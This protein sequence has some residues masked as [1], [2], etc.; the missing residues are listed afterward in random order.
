MPT[1]DL[2]EHCYRFAGGRVALAFSLRLLEDVVAKLGTELKGSFPDNPHVMM[3]N[4]KLPLYDLA[5]SAFI[6]TLSLD[7]SGG[8]ARLFARAG[9]SAGSA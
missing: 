8:S 9:S 5:Y 4:A 2:Q 7:L 1:T 3:G 6:R